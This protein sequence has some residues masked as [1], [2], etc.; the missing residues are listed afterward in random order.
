MGDPDLI[1]LMKSPHWWVWILAETVLVVAAV[2]VWRFGSSVSDIV[3]PLLVLAATL[4]YSFLSLGVA[5]SSNVRGAM[6]RP[7]AIVESRHWWF[8]VIG[9]VF[10]L[11][12][13]MLLVAYVFNTI[14]RA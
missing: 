14:I 7:E 2:L 1:H 13:S 9:G 11:L 5:L 6:V 10:G 4:L 8:L 12:W 3:S